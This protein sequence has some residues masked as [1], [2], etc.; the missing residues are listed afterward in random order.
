MSKKTIYILKHTNINTQLQLY[1]F[2][3]KHQKL[4]KLFK[5]EWLNG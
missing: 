4:R 2:K 1:N 3:T 5:R